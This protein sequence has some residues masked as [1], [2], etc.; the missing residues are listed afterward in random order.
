MTRLAGT[1]A[2][3]ALFGI[4]NFRAQKMCKMIFVNFQK[5]RTSYLNITV[6]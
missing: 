6:I 5:F 3:F 2:L 1:F 4:S